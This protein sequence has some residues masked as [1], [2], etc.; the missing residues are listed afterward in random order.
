M[1]AGLFEVLDLF[2]GA[3]D[4]GLHFEAE[5]GEAEAEGG[6]AGGFD[7]GAGVS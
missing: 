7:P 3:F 6:V 2:A 1:V 5:G 4:F